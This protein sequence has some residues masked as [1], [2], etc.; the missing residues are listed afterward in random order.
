MKAPAQTTRARP[1]R[2]ARQAD[3]LPSPDAFI[4]AEHLRVQQEIE[5]RAHQFWLAKGGASKSALN[6]WLAA[7]A[8]VL[9]E[10]VGRRESFLTRPLV[11]KASPAKTGPRPLWLPEIRLHP[12]VRFTVQPLACP[13]GL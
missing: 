6:D 10:F 5:A 4:L 8:E 9:T 2:A 11:A 3:P 12:Q 1:A 13:S 7:E